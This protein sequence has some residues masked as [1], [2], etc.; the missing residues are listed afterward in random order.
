MSECMTLNKESQIFL[1][2][3]NMISVSVF[4]GTNNKEIRQNQALR[5]EP[6]V[7]MDRRTED[8]QQN[9][10]KQKNKLINQ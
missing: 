4:F 9:L 5:A 3:S 1:L 8:E 6:T 7:I 2:C 10:G